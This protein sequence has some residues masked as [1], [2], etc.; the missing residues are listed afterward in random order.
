MRPSIGIPLDLDAHGRWKPGRT[1]QYLDAAYARALDEA[2]AVPLLLPLQDDPGALLD[3]LDG[4]LIPGGD[5]F[6]PPRPYPP[7][8]RFE[9]VPEAQLAFDRAL[10]V[11]AWQARLPLLGLCYGMQMLVLERG[12]S[13]HYD[14]AT[15]VPEAG[16]H[17]LREPDA[18]HAVR[19]EPSSRL[20]GIFGME[21]MPVNS[22][23]H[24]AVA[25]PGDGLRVCARAEDGV[26]EAVEGQGGA[27]VLGVQ[28]HP[29]SLDTAHRRALFG[30]FVAACR[31]RAA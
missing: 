15:D 1:Y 31:A 12:G 28:W 16:E 27:F 22:R 30:A 24:Q 19:L 7:G 9:P 21:R 4:L 11:A 3:R 13:L 17:L 26:V 18:R 6:L 5:D 25:A 29:E 23:H 2:G 14:L 10:L 8:V 20:A